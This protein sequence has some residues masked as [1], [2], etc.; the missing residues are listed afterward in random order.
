MTMP[1]VC[2]S[3]CNK[4][5]KRVMIFG[6]SPYNRYVY[7]VVCRKWIL[8]YLVG[9]YCLCC[10][11]NIRRRS[12]HNMAKNYYERDPHWEESESIPIG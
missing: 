5:G 11:A 8:K 10:G 2:N 3:K 12:H 7:C 1:R 6:E 4:Y 9:K